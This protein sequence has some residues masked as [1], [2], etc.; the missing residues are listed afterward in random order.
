ML[1]DWGFSLSSFGLIR[2]V[3]GFGRRSIGACSRILFFFL[4]ISDFCEPVHDNTFSWGRSLNETFHCEVLSAKNSSEFSWIS[5]KVPRETL[6]V[7]CS[8]R[9]TNV[10]WCYTG[11]LATQIRNACFLHEFANLSHFWIAFNAL[12]HCKYRQKTFATG[13]Y[14]RMIFCATSYHCKLALQVDQCNITFSLVI[15]VRIFLRVC[16]VPVKQDNLSAKFVAWKCF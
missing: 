1:V 14:T 9:G 4:V 2:N 8:Q 15:E 13:R 5:V 16:R 12:K 6:Q 10:R 7:K 3:D 11:Q